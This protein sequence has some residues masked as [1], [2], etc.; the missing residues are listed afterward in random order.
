M[1]AFIR[2]YNF[3]ALEMLYESVFTQYPSDAWEVTLYIVQRP[4]PLQPTPAWL[5]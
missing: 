2:D 1:P 4:R 3:T 5:G